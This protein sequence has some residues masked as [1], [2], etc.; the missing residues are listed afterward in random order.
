[1][2]WLREWWPCVLVLTHTLAFWAGRYWG[3]A[4]FAGRLADLTM[5]EAVELWRELQGED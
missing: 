5:G 2:H 3:E 4:G 1:M